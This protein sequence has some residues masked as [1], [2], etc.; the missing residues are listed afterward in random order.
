MIYIDKTFVSRNSKPYLISEIGL[1]HNGDFNEAINLINDSHSAN[2]DA[3]KFQ[4]RSKSFFKSKIEKMEIGQQYVYEYVKNTYLTYEE[5]SKLFKYAKKLNLDL[6][7]SCWDVESLYFAKEV[8]I[9]TIKIA[10][11]DLTNR[12]LIEK[13]LSL[14][15]NI[16]IS[17]GMSTQDELEKSISYILEKCKS[18][19]ILHCS[20]AYPAPIS[21]LNL[22]FIS[23]LRKS[24]PDLVIGYSGHE[25][26]YHVCLIAQALGAN[27]FEKHITRNKSS[28]GNDH[29]VSLLKE[30]ML[31]LTK[32]LSDG[33]QSLGNS[34]NRLIQAGEK[35]NRVSLAKSLC[36]QEDK[37]RG[38]FIKLNDLNFTHGG[39]GISPNNY[40]M[41]LDKK[42]IRDKLSGEI[43]E[44]SDF[45]EFY[46]K[47][48]LN[49]SPIKN[50]DLGIPVRY[51][52]AKIL[53]EELETTFLEFHLSY[54]DID[55][56]LDEIKN[57]FQD[58]N[59]PADH[60]FHS[61]DFYSN[62][63]I[64]DPLNED[65]EISNQSDIE[66]RRFLDHISIIR[67][68]YLKKSCNKTKII[69]S[70]SCAT[71]RKLITREDKQ[72]KYQKLKE[73]IQ[74]INTCYP[75]LEILPQTLPVNAW[76]LGGRR[77][78]NIFADPR[79][80]YEYCNQS[81]LR[82]CLDTAHTIMA[83]NF[84]K[85]N[86][87][88][89]LSK[90]LKYADHVHLVDAKGEMDEGLNFGEGDLNLSKFSSEMTLY[91]KLSYIPEVWQGHHNLGEGFKEAIKKIE[92]LLLK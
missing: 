27:V 4:I 33:Y 78:V 82:I 47:E 38:E 90:L 25:L 36:L 40:E 15:E 85:L 2:C 7:V 37:K 3:V 60:T 64:F 51:H 6:I 45:T 81:N 31:N 72:I 10:S 76:Y 79:E 58:L 23:R 13:I 52:D 73:Y 84:F 16:I 66:Y 12:L 22:N 65:S 62:D 34:E 92:S 14:F 86:S 18:L 68:F 19:C 61:P 8:G 44:F 89:W 43:L 17:T 88:E 70:F 59:F 49:L 63:L 91:H 9:K 41:I 28:R 69:T 83:C 75:E 67:N 5:Y 20:S 50:C 35:M 87:E 21:T 74:K 54:K 55:I 29:K 46:K 48:S 26:E 80:I 42:L 39:K 57:I 53:H 30:E 32:M 56:P 11:A 71:L 1:N 24:Y 77:Y